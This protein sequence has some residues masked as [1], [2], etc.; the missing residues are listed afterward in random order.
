MNSLDTNVLVYAV[1]R[2]CE[3]HPKALNV[4]ESMLE[5]P[6]DWIVSDQVLFEFYRS[7]R[8][9]KILEKPLSHQAAM[10]QIIFL[11]EQSGVMHCSY[12]TSF[13]DLMKKDGASLNPKAIHIFDKVLAVTL[14]QNG[15]KCFYTR[16]EK[17]FREFPFEKIINPID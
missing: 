2:G 4:Y 1:N 16:N 5:T 17:D 15:V 11:R 12:E 14:L 8:H 3:E 13:W 10:E 7:L 9:P 6:R